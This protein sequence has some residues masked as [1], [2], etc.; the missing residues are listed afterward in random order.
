MPT[1]PHCSQS[2]KVG[3]SELTDVEKA[4]IDWAGPPENGRPNIIE[5]KHIKA[6]A[7]YYGVDDWLSH[8]DKTLS[9]E[10]NEEIF[11]KLS[12]E[13]DSEGPTMQEIGAREAVRTGHYD[14]Y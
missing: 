11:R 3:Q 13:R 6:I 14:G 12:T 8:W 9:P 1:C 2:I 5:A 7:E 4:Q 10:E